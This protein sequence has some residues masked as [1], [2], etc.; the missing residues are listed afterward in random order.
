MS[1]WTSLRR[2]IPYGAISL[3]F[4]TARAL[5]L[6]SL[7]PERT[8]VGLLSVLLAWP[9]AVAFYGTHGLFPIRLSVFYNLLTVAHPGLRNFILPIL[10]VFAGAALLCYASRSSDVWAFL[11]VWCAIML[12]PMLNVTLWSNAENVHDRYLYSAIDR[13][14]CDACPTPL[15]AKVPALHQNGSGCPD[16]DRDRIRLRDGDGDTVLAE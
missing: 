9:Q 1:L 5:A 2:A 16:S 6:K 8:K 4:L 13:R 7:T 11:S 15:V 10:V 12:V 3:L 14:V